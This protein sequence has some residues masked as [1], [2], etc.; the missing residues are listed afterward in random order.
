MHLSGDGGCCCWGGVE[1]RAR[2]AAALAGQLDSQGRA[3]PP[4]PPGS[5]P[6]WHPRAPP[7][8]TAVQPRD[9]GQPVSADQQVERHSHWAPLH[10][11]EAAAQRGHRVHLPH[12]LRPRA[13]APAPPLAGGRLRSPAAGSRAARHSG[14]DA[15][16]RLQRPHR[17]MA[18]APRPQ[19]RGALQAARLAA[20]APS[21]PP[22]PLA[23]ALQL[24]RPAARL[25]LG[26]LLA[27]ASSTV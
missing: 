14:G 12:L 18:G 23:P 22:P 19:A 27:S 8:L 4:P 7:V 6:S 5:H 10:I 2:A 16:T 13:P 26:P 1:C 11:L 21:P 17:G 25:L 3:L 24:R 20:A 15:G 9:L